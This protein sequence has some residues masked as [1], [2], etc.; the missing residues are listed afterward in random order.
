[1]CQF[2]LGMPAKAMLLEIGGV[3]N[4]AHHL[5]DAIEGPE[6]AE[7]D[8][9]VAKAKQDVYNGSG[10]QATSQHDPW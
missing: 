2:P 10:H 9:G 6:A 8:H 5:K 1:M 4:I 3:G 7:P